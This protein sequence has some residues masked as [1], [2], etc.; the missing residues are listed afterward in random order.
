MLL[1]NDLC[2]ASNR[3]DVEETCSELYNYLLDS[4][5]PIP[6][7]FLQ[8]QKYCVT[9]MLMDTLS[10]QQ[11]EVTMDDTRRLNESRNLITISLTIT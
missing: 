10:Q 11:E 1:L 3:Q 6:T 9:V 5:K 4:I 7:T 2:R 8:F